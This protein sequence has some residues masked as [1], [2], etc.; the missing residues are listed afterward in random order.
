M[1]DDVELSPSASPVKRGR[2]RPRL[3]ATESPQE[4]IER[5]QAE[6]QHAREAQK[7]AEQHRAKI[8]GA[9]VLRHAST[10]AD[11]RRQLA[12]ILRISMNLRGDIK[13]KADLAAI[14]ELAGELEST[15]T[16]SPSS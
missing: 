14:R 2:G 8:V 7:I 9:V 11:F 6:L 13:S 15:S 5:L 12:G 1:P 10:D 4:R 16:P 3:I